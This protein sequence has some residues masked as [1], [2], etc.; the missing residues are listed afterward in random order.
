MKIFQNQKNSSILYL[1]NYIYSIKRKTRLGIN[2][3]CINRS[4]KASASSPIDLIENL[5]QYDQSSIT[6]RGIHSH[7]SNGNLSK[8][9]KLKKRT[10]MKN[11]IKDQLGSPRKIISNSLKGETSDII[12]NVGSQQSLQRMLRRER[13]KVVSSNINFNLADNFSIP[14]ETKVTVSGS[15]FFQY[16]PSNRRHLDFNLNIVI[17]FF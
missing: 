11:S 10:E 3:R 14:E 1:N 7:D 5:E 2:W 6:L 9:L 13:R 16:G 4:C 15:K 17:F 8:I 12:L